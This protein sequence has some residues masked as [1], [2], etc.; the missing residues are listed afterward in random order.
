MEDHSKKQRPPKF[1][2]SFSLL[3]ILYLCY[4]AYTKNIQISLQKTYAEERNLI[5]Q[6]L[7]DQCQGICVNQENKIFDDHLVYYHEYLERENGETRDQLLSSSDQEV[8]DTESGDESQEQ[9]EEVTAEQSKSKELIKASVSKSF[10]KK[11]KSKIINKSGRQSFQMQQRVIN[12]DDDDEEGEFDPENVPEIFLTD[13][14]RPIIGQHGSVTVRKLQ[15][16]YSDVDSVGF[17]QLM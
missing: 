12:L 2:T 8:S 15:L 10:I 5:I 6:E 9:P 16:L 14:I 11:S 1:Y 7:I 4:K 17:R 3:K 13:L